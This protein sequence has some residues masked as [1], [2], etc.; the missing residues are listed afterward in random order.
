MLKNWL[1][2]MLASR[3]VTLDTYEM[4]EKEQNEKLAALEKRVLML[5]VKDV[6]ATVSTGEDT[7]TLVTVGDPVSPLADPRS[8]CT[9][10]FITLTKVEKSSKT[11][12]KAAK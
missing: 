8:C 5:E 10:G 6:P 3:F 12:K 9:T 2:K 7:T 1:C 11:K 4:D